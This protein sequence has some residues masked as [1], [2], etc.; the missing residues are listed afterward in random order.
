M[1]LT[2]LT[3]REKIFEDEVQEVMLPG[4]D[5]EFS[6]WDFHQPFLYRLNEGII[7]IVA[8]G[9]KRSGDIKTFEINDGM[10]KMN[11]NELTIMIEV[12]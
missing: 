11:K 6:V 2:I 12:S 9:Q 8:R 5:G 3:P 4:A 10:A 1:K 7:R